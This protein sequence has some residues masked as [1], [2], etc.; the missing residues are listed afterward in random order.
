ML[1][2]PENVTAAIDAIKTA[3]EKDK[4]KWKDIDEKLEKVLKAKYRLGLNKTQ[5]VETANLVADLNR[6]TDDIRSLV[7][8]NS[9]TVLHNQNN[10]FPFQRKDA[11]KKIA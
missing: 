3:I 6:N 5:F 11:N 8:R 1:C 4:L 2:L 7:A 9:L 10:F